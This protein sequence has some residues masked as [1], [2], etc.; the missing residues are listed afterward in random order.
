MG[1]HIDLDLDGVDPV[2]D[3]SYVPPAPVGSEPCRKCGDPIQRLDS[4]WWHSNGT[5]AD[6]HRAKPER[7]PDGPIA[8][9]DVCGGGVCCIAGLWFHTHWSSDHTAVP[10]GDDHG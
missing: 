2:D 4:E 3:P 6:G 9:C 10:K 8:V 7:Q 5:P 1:K